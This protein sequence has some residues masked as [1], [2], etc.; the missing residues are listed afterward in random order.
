MSLNKPTA[1]DILKPGQSCYS[2]VIGVAKRARQLVDE[3]VDLG[4][5][6]PEKPVCEAIDE[7]KEGRC[8]L[9]EY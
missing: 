1:W 7:F 5:E 9:I 3:A 4:M 6:P 8:I 2:L